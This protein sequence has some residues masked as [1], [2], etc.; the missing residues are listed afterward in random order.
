MADVIL[1]ARYILSYE[2]LLRRVNCSVTLPYWD[3]SVFSLTPWHTNRTRIWHDGPSGLGGDGGLD[4]CVQNGLFRTKTNGQCLRRRFNGL[5]PDI[6]AVY[7]TQFHQPNV[8]GFNAF[9]LNLRVNLHDTVHC[10]VGG[11]MCFVTSANAPEFFLH[12]CFIDRIWANWQEYSEEHMTVHFSGLSGNM[13]ETGYRP[14]QFI[15]TVDL[16]DIRYPNNTGRRTCVSYEDPTHGEYDEIIERLDGMTHD[17]ILKVPRHSFAPLNTRQLSFFNVNKQERRQARRNLRRE[18]E[19]RNELTGDAG[20]TGTDRDT[21]FRLASLPVND[22]NKRSVL[23][24]K[25]NTM[26]DRWMAKNDKQK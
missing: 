17:E 4:G 23:R 12:H 24:R 15:N 21:G 20:L 5:P 14:A 25:K 1:L 3:W 19:P 7:L 2:N 16:P 9:E 13:S 8:I 10:R 22:G 11:D 6:I 26:R 18:L